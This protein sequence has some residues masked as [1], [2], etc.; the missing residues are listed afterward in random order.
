MTLMGGME[1]IVILVV[2]P[3]L[4]FFAGLLYWALYVQP[5]AERS[6][7]GKTA[8]S[9][10]QQSGLGQLQGANFRL[11]QIVPDAKL[12][13]AQYHIQDET[14]SS[15]ANYVSHSTKSATLEHNADT[16]T[17]F[18]Q[19]SSFGGS[20]FAGKIGG[21]SNDSMLIRSEARVWA[22]IFRVKKFPVRE[23]RCAYAGSDYQIR[24]P[25]LSATGTGTIN[26]RGAAVGGFRR[27]AI[28][29]RNIFLALRTDL[30]QELAVCLCAVA[31]LK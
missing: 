16:A 14:G 9:L 28:S 7:A 23:Y 18:I 2:A 1:G 21:T 29:Q 31:L 13:V 15:I 25:G 5:R 4:V 11:Y 30:P 19:W 8:V 10:W 17:V 26:L 27:P 24:A 12:S 3:V 22:E 6:T 20:A